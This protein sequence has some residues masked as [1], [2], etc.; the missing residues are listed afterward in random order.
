MQKLSDLPPE[1][2]SPF[3]Y[4]GLDV[5]GPW[6]VVAHHTRGGQAHSKRWAVLFTCMTTC[7]V[8]TEV[9]M[10]MDSLSCINAL[11]RFFAIRGPAKQMHSDCGTNF[12]G[13]CN[14]LEFHKVMKETKVQRYIINKECTWVFNLIGLACRILDSMLMR[15]GHSNLS[16]EVLCTFMVEVTAIIN[17][18]PLVPVSMDA[19]SPLILSPAMLLTQN[20]GTPPPAGNFSVKDIYNRQVQRLANQFWCCWNQ[21][22]LQ[23][24]QVC[25]K[26]QE[27]YPNIQE[28]DIVLLKDNQVTRNEWPM[29]LVTKC[30][31]WSRWKGSQG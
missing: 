9:I 3:T 23:T 29:A 16:D 26:W 28:G 2:L 31:P 21:E 25:H 1:Q 30:F 8:H 24:L 14:E 15:E 20:L 22:Y 19:D 18:R 12:I 7:V 13:A 4:T 10:S 27:L 6:T 11:H 17:N 5:F